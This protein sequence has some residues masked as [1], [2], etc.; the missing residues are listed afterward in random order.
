[1]ELKIKNTQFYNVCYNNFLDLE[2]IIIY[3]EMKILTTGNY[4]YIDNSTGEIVG[5]NLNIDRS[6]KWVEDSGILK[7]IKDS[8]TIDNLTRSLKCSKKRSLDNIF[9]YALSNKFDYFIT[10]TFSPE[11]VDR[12]NNED[13]KYHWKLFRQKLQYLFNDVK[14]LAI[15]EKHPTS[16]K[17]HLHCLVGNCNLKQWLVKAY[18][19]HTGKPLKSKGKQVYNLELFDFGF[20]TVVC[21]D[22]NSL[23]V[24]NYLSKYVVKDFGTLGYN[25]KSYYNTYNLDFKDKKLS[26]FGTKELTEFYNNNKEFVYKE[27]KD[28]IVYRKRVEF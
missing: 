3:K 9:G 16:G 26:F 13:I 22:N 7:P 20:S 2:E 1:M 14:I 27:T 11:F 6:R 23:R 17:L 19:P 10:L 4:D 5:L 15:P 24:A 25:S 21:L 8:A 18:N 12:D 28:F